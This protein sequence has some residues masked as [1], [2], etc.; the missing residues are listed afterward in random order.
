MAMLEDVQKSSSFRFV[1]SLMLLFLGLTLIFMARNETNNPLIKG[2]MKVLMLLIDS[3]AMA[4]TGVLSKLKAQPEFL[5]P[6]T[7]VNL[8]SASIG[9]ALPTGKPETIYLYISI[10]LFVV[11]FGASR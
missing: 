5:F 7:L 11:A 6:L 1:V 2:A 9:K 10:F 8:M 4:I 3:F